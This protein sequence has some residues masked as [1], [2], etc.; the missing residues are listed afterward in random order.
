MDLYRTLA[1]FTTLTATIA[2]AACAAT[3]DEPRADLAASTAAVARADGAGGDALASMEMRNARG[4]L[5]EANKAA[6][7]GE[8][9][10]ARR[11]AHEAEADAHHAKA[12]ADSAKALKAA[13]ELEE[14]TRVLRLELDRKTP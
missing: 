7:A 8:H 9:G 12:K 1:A 2:L 10:R 5:I 3:P 13:A 4:K 14:S 11:L 6:A